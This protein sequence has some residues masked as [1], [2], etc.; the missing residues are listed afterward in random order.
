MNFKLNRNWTRD[1]EKDENMPLLKLN[2]R[3]SA[4]KK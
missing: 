1:D 3:I 2:I 4:H